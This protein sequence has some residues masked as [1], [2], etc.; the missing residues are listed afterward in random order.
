MIKLKTVQSED[1]ELLWNIHQKYL[2]EMTKYYNDEM[3]EKG[4]YHYRFFDAYFSEPERIALFIYN[5]ETLVGFAMLNPYSYVGKQPDHVLAEFTIFPMYRK[6]HIGR[7]AA[8]YILE[9]FKGT[10]E[11]KYNNNNE[12]AA[13]LWT[14]ITEHHRPAKYRYSDDETVL[15]FS[16]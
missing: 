12:G 11:I 16:I 7:A 9:M 15:V 3:D 8:E 4:N 10:W 5:D 13:A 6:K 1:K 2:Y 14:K